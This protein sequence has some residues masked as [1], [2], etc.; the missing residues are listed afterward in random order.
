[1]KVAQCFHLRAA[2]VVYSI[3]CLFYLVR[4]RRLQTLLRG[5]QKT[6]LIREEVGRIND[7]QLPWD[8]MQAWMCLRQA[9]RLSAD[10]HAHDT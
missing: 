4:T 6:S 7:R 3:L 2:V 10:M 5:V 8:P 9:S 1:M